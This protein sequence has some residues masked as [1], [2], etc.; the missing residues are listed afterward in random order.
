MH[1]SAILLEKSVDQRLD[2]GFAALRSVGEVAKAWATSSVGKEVHGVR[3][4]CTSRLMRS[5]VAIH[6]KRGRADSVF[7]LDFF[8]R[9][10]TLA[11]MFL[12]TVCSLK[13]AGRTAS[14]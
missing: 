14:R 2:L 4:F 5:C 1:V 9:T 13:T 3:V 6:L 7:V 11:K 8:I 10:W 12:P